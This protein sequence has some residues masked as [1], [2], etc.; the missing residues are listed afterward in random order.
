MKTKTI[1]IVKEAVVPI[2]KFIWTNREEI[3]EIGKTITDKVKELNKERKEY[4]SSNQRS[5]NSNLNDYPEK[6]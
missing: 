2:I 3:I 5:S 6:E 4:K 1:I